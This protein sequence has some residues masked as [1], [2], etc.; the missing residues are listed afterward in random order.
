MSVCQ[1]ENIV[2]RPTTKVGV[3]GRRPPDSNLALLKFSELLFIL[4]YLVYFAPQTLVCPHLKIV[5]PHRGMFSSC[6]ADCASR[7][8]LE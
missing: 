5:L 3:R 4:L 8:R 2:L 1:S 6:G 7:L